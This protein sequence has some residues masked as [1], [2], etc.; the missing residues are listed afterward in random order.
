L[1]SS[2][3]ITLGEEVCNFYIALELGSVLEV[4]PVKTN[5]RTTRAANPSPLKVIKPEY[6]NFKVGR[7]AA[8]PSTFHAAYF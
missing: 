6:G 7:N 3:I 8:K 5:A 4:K 1:P 2:R